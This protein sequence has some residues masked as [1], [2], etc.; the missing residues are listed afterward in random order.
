MYRDRTAQAEARIALLEERLREQAEENLVLRHQIAKRNQAVIEVVHATR[1]K[2]D[3][4]ERW[5][6]TAAILTTVFAI[7]AA[8][9]AVAIVVV[10]WSAPIGVQLVHLP[11]A[12]SNL[13]TGVDYTVPRPTYGRQRGKAYLDE[14]LDKGILYGRLKGATATDSELRTLRSICTRYDD[15]FCRNAAQRELMK[16]R[17]TPEPTTQRP[18]LFERE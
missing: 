12:R 9:V 4:R 8:V 14:M 7:A 2:L 15:P 17:G 6:Q 11:A 18:G 10:S 5:W 3:G 16:R 13:D 1:K